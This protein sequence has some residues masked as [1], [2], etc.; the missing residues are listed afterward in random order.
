MAGTLTLPQQ[1]DRQTVFVGS[2]LGPMLFTFLSDNLYSGNAAVFHHGA[3][4][5]VLVRE[6]RTTRG[7]LPRAWR[8]HKSSL[9][10]WF[11]V[12]PLKC[13][14]VNTQVKSREVSGS[15]AD[16]VRCLF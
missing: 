9:T 1:H 4:N 11:Y 15:H 2:A 8:L 13:G 10:R 16:C 6:P 5:K 12:N 3:D 7:D 14:A